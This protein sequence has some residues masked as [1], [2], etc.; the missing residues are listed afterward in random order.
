MNRVDILIILSGSL[1]LIFFGIFN[2]VG[3]SQMAYNMPAFPS[4]LLYGTTIMYTI[5]F[6]IIALIIRDNPFEKR[7]L[8]WNNQKHY[9]K[10]GLLTALNGLFFQFSAPWV[11]GALSQV[12]ANMMILQIP[13]FE[14]IFIRNRVK[15][16]DRRWWIGMIIVF[17]GIGIGMVPAIL[18]IIANHSD[19]NPAEISDKWY[20]ILAFIISTTFQ[21]WE[22][23]AQDQAFHD[24]HAAVREVSCLAWYNL[25]SI[26]MYLITIPL[27][28]VP[29]LNGTTQGTS[30]GNAFTNQLGAI[31][32]FLGHPYDSDVISGGCQDG[33]TLWPLIFVI[34]YIGMFGVNAALINRYGVLFPN[35]VGANI[36][37][38]SALVFMI[39]AIVGTYAVPFSFWPLVGCGIVVIGIIAKGAPN[40][41]K[42]AIDPV[43]IPEVSS[44]VNY[45][46]RSSL[47]NNNGAE[48]Q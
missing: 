45:N 15:E 22:Q 28:A 47:I 41:K 44:S 18:K 19:N 13:V 32:C 36:E 12:L 38:T 29:Y 23:V 20:W 40:N 26:P 33:S 16:R 25:Y 4:F 34:G 17:I 42:I 7:H 2:N 27:E 37:L 6:W 5:G 1:F 39:P 43:N 11:D 21:A 35:I 46:E 10:L 3:G 30:I 14:R 9:L 48:Y 8:K 24:D 31:L